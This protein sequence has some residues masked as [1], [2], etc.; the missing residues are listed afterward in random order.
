MFDGDG[1]YLEVTPAGG[2]VFRL[3]YR[4]DGKEKTFTIS[5]NIRPYHW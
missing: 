4:I 1:L 3:K 2:K 5:V